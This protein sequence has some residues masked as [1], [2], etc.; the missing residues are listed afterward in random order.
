M[1]KPAADRGE[2]GPRD[3]FSAQIVYSV[4]IRFSSGEIRDVGAG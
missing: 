3:V 2:G 4:Y 1:W